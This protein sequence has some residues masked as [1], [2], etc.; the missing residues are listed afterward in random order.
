MRAWKPLPVCV[1]TSLVGLP[2]M[3]LASKTVQRP[4]MA[5]ERTCVRSRCVDASFIYNQC[6]SGGYYG[7][8]LDVRPSAEVR[9]P[10][11]SGLGRSPAPLVTLATG[12]LSLLRDSS[13]R[14]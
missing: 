1:H 5:S 3:T 6:L 14:P 13:P 12:V 10:T 9:L 4:A 7:L 2:Q 11:L 8:L